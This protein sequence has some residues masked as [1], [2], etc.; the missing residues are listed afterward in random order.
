MI[1]HVESQQ[2]SKKGAL[3]ESQP[4]RKEHGTVDTEPNLASANDAYIPTA[5]AFAG[6]RLDDLPRHESVLERRRKE[7]LQKNEP[8]RSPTKP[9]D[10]RSPLVLK[11]HLSRLEREKLECGAKGDHGGVLSKKEEE[12]TVPLE[13]LM[14]PHVCAMD[15]RKQDPSITGKYA[16]TASKS[17]EEHVGSLELK[18]HVCRLDRDKLAF[19]EKERNG[20]ARQ[21]V[22]RRKSRLE[23][24]K[25]A[26]EELYPEATGDEVGDDET[27]DREQRVRSG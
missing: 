8:R 27:P 4:N 14:R 11:P 7:A 13:D 12:P 3:A 10:A 23:L 25:E 22:Q 24:E 26:I 1:A 9:V 20:D 6:I 2:A 18:Q 19:Q 17:G 15:R 16:P 5:K 21:P